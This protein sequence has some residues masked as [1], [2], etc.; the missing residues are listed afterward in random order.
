MDV[1]NLEE[2]GF[3]TLLRDILKDFGYTAY[4]EY[5]THEVMTTSSSVIVK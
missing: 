3:P 4:S 1:N 5:L 2:G